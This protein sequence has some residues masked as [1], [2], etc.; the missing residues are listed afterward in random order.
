VISDEAVEAA[1][2]AVAVVT[3]GLVSWKLG[4]AAGFRKAALDQ[5]RPALRA[6]KEW[7]K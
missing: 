1:A 6:N 2:V 3:V 4:W 7:A 5:P